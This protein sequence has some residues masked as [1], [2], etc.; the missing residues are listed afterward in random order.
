MTDL[1]ICSLKAS[2]CLVVLYIPFFLVLKK[3]THFGF[4]RTYLLLSM[5]VSFFL[6]LIEIPLIRS[7]NS[8]AGFSAM[9]AA[10]Q[11]DGSEFEATNNGV[12]VLKIGVLVY[13]L[14]LIFFSIRFISMLISVI[15]IHRHCNSENIRGLKIAKCDYEIAPF[16]F[17]RTIYIFDEKNDENQLDKIIA[18]EAVHVRQLHSLDVLAAEIICLLTWFNPVCWIIKAAL[19]ET[20]EYLADS[21]VSEQSSG[22]AE[23]FLLLIRN[24]IGVQPGLANNFNKSLTLKRLIMMKKPRSG[25]LSR[26]KAMLAIP[27]LTL[28]FIAFSCNNKANDANSTNSSSQL[29]EKTDGAIDKM[30]EFPGGQEALTKFIIDNVKYPEAAKK[31]GTQGKVLVSFVVTKTGKLDKI[32]ISQKVDDLLDAEAL[33][34]IKA[35]PDWVPGEDN[36]AKVEVEMILPI[37]F[38]LA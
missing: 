6:P 34:V 8:G 29:T 31:N 36:G 30:P 37:S 13:L 23:Y 18:H 5:V 16:S 20:H 21:G 27:L 3:E 4:N 9:L 26:L 28:L 2:V 11:V 1:L 15:S 19:K 10:V 33:R 35:M 7:G 12:S 25:R 24:A 14:G 38:K 17:L 32:E 22:S